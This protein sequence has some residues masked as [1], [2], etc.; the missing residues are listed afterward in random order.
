MN[1]VD[2]CRVSELSFLMFVGIIFV[3]LLALGD[4]DDL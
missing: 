2:K 1:F 3:L 4:Q